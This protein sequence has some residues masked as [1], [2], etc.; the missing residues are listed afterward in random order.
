MTE[1]R[2]LI[3][4]NRAMVPTELDRQVWS[5]RRE[6][7][8]DGS[9]PS[10]NLRV[11][12]LAGTVIS[13]INSHAA[14]LV[15]IASFIYGADQSVSRGGIADV[16]GEDWRRHMTL[17][18]PVTEPGFWMQESVRSQ[19]TDVLTF[20]TD[21]DWEFHFC[22]ADGE[23]QQISLS[24]EDSTLLG[25]PD[26][27]ILF[28]GGADSLCTTVEA[29]VHNNRRPVLISHRP[30]PHL[31]SRQRHLS[32]HLRDRFSGWTF[33]HLSFWIHRKGS[34]AADTSQ[35][36]RSFLFA[37]LGAAIAAELGLRDI[38]LGDNGIVSLNLPIN[39]QLVGALASRSTHPKFIHSF[40]SLLSEIFDGQ[41]TISNPLSTRTR[42]EVLGILKAADCPELLAETNSCSHT[43]G[44]PA[45]TPHCGY[46]SQCVDRRFGAIAAG[47]QEYD[48]G[49]RYE[50]DLFVQSLRDGE[51]RTIAE[52]FV[53]FARKI[54]D[55]PEETLFD[56]F[57]Q[58]FDCI[59]PTDVTPHQTAL[60]ATTML[61]RHASNVLDVVATMIARNRHELAENSLPSDCL[62]RLVA[63][64]AVRSQD[65]APEHENVFR[66]DGQNWT[67]TYQGRTQLYS[68]AKGMAYLARLLAHPGQ[69]FRALDL[70]NDLSP[71][72]GP[73]DATRQT[74]RSSY[75]SD[76][77]NLRAQGSE[78][79]ESILDQQAR[80]EYRERLEQLKD[81]QS[82]AGHSK[83]HDL[84][85]NL[86][87]EIEFLEQELKT[88]T[89][90]SGRSRKFP[91]QA[92]R[93]RQAVGNNIRRSLKNLADYHPQLHRHLK[94]S[95]KIGNFC[96][97]QEDPAPVWKT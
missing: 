59:L 8:S 57:P 43:R 27:V 26:S 61:K 97:Y 86:S 35:R 51:P 21:D 22:E 67:V 24:L 49:D 55:V 82:R 64:S 92:E 66:R 33:P 94:G 4:C 79:S 93:A 54:H 52:S 75:P 17:C 80:R 83:D 42:A 89:G 58:L 28:S 44:R 41:I 91:G 34:D 1:T 70:A 85:V 30:S 77:E 16:Y 40:N 32:G 15:R 53:R 5:Y 6:L 71:R 10:L 19:I 62:L 14:D 74:S 87:T 96:S 25:S 39:D 63:G 50:L 69:E 76:A 18:I 65:R 56:E 23:T 31:D 68:H 38:F 37:S 78:S 12:S 9:S 72:D 48:P 90:L 2:A 46:C 11:Q 95:I 45:E 3:R 60:D 47:L 84:M 13:S 36:S 7:D 88:S 20:L 81:L 29:V 73:I